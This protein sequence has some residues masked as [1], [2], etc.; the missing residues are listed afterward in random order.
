MRVTVVFLLTLLTM[1]ASAADSQVA[2]K[3]AGIYS[4][5]RY[6]EETGDLIGLEVMVIPQGDKDAWNAVIQV[7]EGGA[8]LVVIVPLEPVGDH[9][10]FAM[11]KD[12]FLSHIRCAVHF[13]ATEAQL[14]GPACFDERLLRCTKSYWE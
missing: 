12:G 11:P 7:A 5:L 1:V 10:E 8:P 13:L 2:V 3:V 9:F 4:T 14:S 6:I